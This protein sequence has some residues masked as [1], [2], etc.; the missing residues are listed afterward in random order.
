VSY[1][2]AATA[3]HA[4]ALQ[5]AFIGSEAQLI[6]HA[7]APPHAARNDATEGF[8]A[9]FQLAQTGQHGSFALPSM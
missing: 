6:A 2:V 1:F 3:A 8:V 5:T 9:A 4:P 7:G